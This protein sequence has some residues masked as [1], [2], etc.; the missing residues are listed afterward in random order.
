V[1]FLKRVEI[2]GQAEAGE[3]SGVLELTS[4]LQV[5]SARNAYGNLL[6]GKRS[7]GA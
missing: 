3:F 7:L 1:I 6:P 2:R 5:I 4:G